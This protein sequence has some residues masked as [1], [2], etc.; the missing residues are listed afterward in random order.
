[1][2]F[3]GK[4][5]LVTGGAG[6]IGEEI[7][8]QFA[9]QG[10][11]AAIIDI[12]AEKGREVAADIGGGSAGDA[13]F[14]RCDLR[15]VSDIQRTVAAVLDDFGRVDVVANVA[16]LANRTVHENITEDEWDLLN[17][18]NLKEPFFVA[19]AAYR[20]MKEQGSGRIINIASYRAH[21]TDG[22]HLIYAATKAGIQA[23]TRDLA[24]GGGPYG[25]TANTVSPG[26]VI[27][28]MTAHNLE[29][30]TWLDRVR[31]RIPL[32]RLLESKEVAHAVLFLASDKASGITGQNLLVDGGWTV[33]E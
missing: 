10:A 5:C 16:G 27:T 29:N 11:V 17:D 8:R 7:A 6:G 19:Q 30:D 31:E 28:P 2:E 24:V 32:G 13:R 4:V 23:I 15:S 14:Y 22:H 25:I 12:D 3:Q 21:T 26:Y 18:V 20:A 1:M 9:A 33:H